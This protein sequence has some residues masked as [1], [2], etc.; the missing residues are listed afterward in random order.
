MSLHLWFLDL[1]RILKVFDLVKMIWTLWKNIRVNLKSY[2][3]WP[4]QALLRYVRRIL[5]N[6]SGLFD[7]CQERPVF[8]QWTMPFF[9]FPVS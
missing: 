7:S 4:R 5:P 9:D 3:E 1:R 8:D 6:D 2:S